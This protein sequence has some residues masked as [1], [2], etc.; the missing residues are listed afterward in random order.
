MIARIP[1]AGFY[2]S[3]HDAEL[4]DALNQ[5]LS[6][7]SGNPNNDLVA[8]AF[9]LVDWSSAHKAYAKAYA[10]NFCE[11][12][13]IAGVFESMTSPRE[14]NFETDK[15]W[16]ELTE[17][18]ARRIFGE[19]D[20]KNLRDQA[21]EMFTSRSG[22]ISFYSPDI[23]TWGDIAEWDYNQLYCLL[24]AYAEQETDSSDGFDSWAESDLMESDRCNGEFDN[25]IY[26]D[27]LER[28]C[29]INDYLRRRESR[30]FKAYLAQENERRNFK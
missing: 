24:S 12:F 2:N 25:M 5:M 15:A 29:K 16:I 20:D 14:Y 3:L 26:N 21:R 23:D 8:R 17:T 22:F 10:E 13:K 1:F 6:D 9:D 28:L 4:D 19:T 11:H 30:S 27:K 18:E 7:D